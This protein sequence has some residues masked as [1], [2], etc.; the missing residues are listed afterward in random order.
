[1]EEEDVNI[2][3]EIYAICANKDPAVH[4][5]Q[6]TSIGR[7]TIKLRATVNTINKD[8]INLHEERE[9]NL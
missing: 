4:P 1:M 5:D 7:D 6:F 2:G 3:D 8:I 9:R